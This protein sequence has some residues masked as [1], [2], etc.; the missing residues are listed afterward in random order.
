MRFVTPRRARQARNAGQGGSSGSRNGLPRYLQAGQPAPPR[1]VLP[2][3]VLPRNE[4]AE[5]EAHDSAGRR[6]HRPAEGAVESNP[7][8]RELSR[9]VAA[10]AGNGERLPDSW[11]ERA[12]RMG[13]PATQVRVHTDARAQRFADRLGAKAVTVGRDIFFA[14]NRYA[15]DTQEGDR[16]L[17]HELTH[18][19]QQ[20]GEPQTLQCDQHDAA[21]TLLGVFSYDMSTTTLNGNPAMGVSLGFFPDPF[22]PYSTRIGMV[23]LANVTDRRT[24]ANGNP[25]D[26]STI[27]R[28]EEAARADTMTTGA[29]TAARG[30]F[31]DAF[32]D[33][34]VH[35]QSSSVEPSYQEP[36]ATNPTAGAYGDYGWLR[37]PTDTHEA[38]LLD[39]PSMSFDCDF[40]FQT[41]ARGVDNQ[42]NYGALEWG[43]QIRGGAIGSDY[44]RAATSSSPAFG[45][46]MDR[47][48]G[49]FSHE[50]L[51]V[52][53]DTTSDTV[54]AAEAA[55]LA[56]ARDYMDR[57][58][59]CRIEV[60]GFADFRGNSGEN[61]GLSLRRAGSVV[62]L[63]QAQ[64][65][66]ADR[67]DTP[68]AGGE[69]TANAPG[70]D[71]RSP[72]AMQANRRVVVRFVRTA[73]STI[74][75]I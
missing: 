11:A 75:A 47:F 27:N 60:S 7:L 15:P 48:R 53:F 33:P 70:S 68:T 25:A 62:A 14:G 35:P 54:S 41:F 28:G 69:T 8:S 66:A 63:L 34:A 57:Y 50:N 74:D 40:D 59:D 67:I 30:W 45:E 73:S 29:G 56:G 18:V 1:Q 10:Q 17:S 12:R 51:I 61:A 65:I 9:S 23:Q 24:A 20:R 32:Y 6:E 58:P 43:F 42:V 44:A 39:T 4:A 21:N 2:R 52:Y 72:G 55:K 38:T 3:Q 5:R 22:G 19:A 64:G 37:S 26:W 71:V 13:A 31:V 49:Y 16:L 36:D 46:A